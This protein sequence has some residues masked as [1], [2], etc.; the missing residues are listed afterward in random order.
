MG[1]LES[2]MREEIAR[3]AKR[4]IRASVAPLKKEVTKLRLRLSHLEK[5][6]AVLD[7]EAGRVRKAEKAKLGHL[8]ASEDEI[9]AARINGKWVQTLRE[10]LNVSQ[11][12]LADLLGISVSGVRTWEYDISKPRGE[13]RSSLVALRKLGRRDIKKMLEAFEEE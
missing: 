7:R 10:K 11:T 1:K 2:V 8:S 4:E 13:N 5:T 3:L 12:E 6:V 9:K